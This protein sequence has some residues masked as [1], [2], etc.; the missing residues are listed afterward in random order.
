MPRWRKITFYVLAALMLAMILGFLWP[1]LMFVVLAWLPIDT[2][3]AMFPGE[4]INAGFV[5]HRIHVLAEGLIFWGLAIGVGLQLWKP[6]KRQAPMLQAL[7]V[8]VAFLVIGLAS[9]SFVAEEEILFV[10][11]VALLALLHPARERFYRFGKP[12]A[13]MAGLAVLAAVPGAFFIIDHIDKQRI[14]LAGDEHAEFAHWAAMAVFSTVLILWGLIGSTDLTGWRVTAWLAGV[15]A[16]TY[17]VSS[18]VFPT[19]PSTVDIG[20][21]IAAIA[22]G[23][24]YIVL[25]ERRTRSTALRSM[26]AAARGVNS[27]V[28]AA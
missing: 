2:W 26:N 21:A 14:N 25:A 27:E 6:R 28:G 10:A 16:A 17:G 4:D 1:I 9:G 18:L 7:A 23:V 15:S 13:A 12:D 24:A 19:M 8:V 20:W 22:W 5:V 3:Q 11:G